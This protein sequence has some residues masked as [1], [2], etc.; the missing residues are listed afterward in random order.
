MTEKIDRNFWRALEGL[1]YSKA[2]G[3]EFMSKRER[4]NE[5]N[6]TDI[7]R[8]EELKSIEEYDQKLEEMKEQIKNLKKIKRRHKKLKELEM[9]QAEIL[10]KMSKREK[11]KHK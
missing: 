7:D 4:E 8:D 3:G 10:K 2:L 9:E 11:N 1:N 5:F 6:I